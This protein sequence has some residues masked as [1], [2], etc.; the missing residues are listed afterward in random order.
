MS[1]TAIQEPKTKQKKEEQNLQIYDVIVIGGGAA[2]CTASIYAVRAGLKTLMLV[3]PT[4]GGQIASSHFVE[5]YPGFPHGISGLDLALSF[6]EQAARVGVEIKRASA[7]SVELDTLVKIVR[8]RREEYK[9]H[10]VII[11][12]GATARKLGVPGEEELRGVGV[13]YCATCD[14]GFAKDKHVA[15]I[16]GGDTA[17]GDAAYLAR[18]TKDVVIVHRRDAFR[19]AKL[20]E[21][22]ALSYP[23]VRVVWNSSV[24]AFEGTDGALSGIRL[25][26]TQTGETSLLPVEHAFVAVGNNPQTAFLENYL[27][28]VDGY[29][30]TDHRCRTELP[31]VY[32]A[33]DVRYN[34]RRQ[35]VTAA[36]DGA[37]AAMEADEYISA[38]RIEIE[39]KKMDAPSTEK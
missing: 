11:A 34:T 1:Q 8:T 27:P 32:A 23:N 4:P 36:A 5:N 38:L 24:E 19:A 17:L 16:G 6:E 35:V 25:K 37:V 13:S 31:G 2:G 9:A 22:V 28:L 7:K 14:G 30:E 29:I 33:G 18:I 10:T 3:G 12:T 20:V 26:N 15:V 21:D 39:K